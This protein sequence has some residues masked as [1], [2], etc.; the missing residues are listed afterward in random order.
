[1]KKDKQPS[2]A[3]AARKGIQETLVKTL[4]TIAGQ[5]QK[6]GIHTDID[7]EKEARKLAKKITKGAKVDEP[8]APAESKPAGETNAPAKAAVTAAKPAASKSAKPAAPKT[9]KVV[10]PAA[11]PEPAASAPVAKPA[12]TPA[13]K[14]A[15]KKQ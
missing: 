4:T 1:M 12:K 14:P 5:L 13:K 15:E 2:P 10:A 7:I 6:K 9:A 3:K 11:T 8:A